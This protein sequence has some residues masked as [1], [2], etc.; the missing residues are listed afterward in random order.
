MKQKNL[1]NMDTK[2]YNVI[3][4]DDEIDSYITA[5]DIKRLLKSKNINIIAT[6]HTSYELRRAIDINYDRVDAVITDANYGDKDINVSDRSLKGLEDVRLCIEKYNERRIIPFY[7]YTGKNE[8]LNDHYQDD[9]LRY[10]DENG[11][12]FTKDET[13]ELFEKIIADVEHINSIEF[14]VRNKY[15]KQLEYAAV[16]EGNDEFLFR[17]LAYEYND[18][19]QNTEDYF[20]SARK[21]VERILVFC[22]NYNVIPTEINTINGC[23][24]FLRGIHH[25]FIPTEE[26]M[27]SALAHSLEFFLNITQD[28]SHGAGDLKLNVDKYVRN[29]KNTNLFRSILYIAM[30]LMEWMVEFVGRHTDKEANKCLYKLNPKYK[31][32]HQGIVYEERE[33]VC[34]DYTII[35]KEGL[36]ICEGDRIGILPGKV[37]IKNNKKIVYSDGFVIIEH[38]KY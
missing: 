22:K 8:Y 19:W 4:A 31:F 5:I 3:W 7:L 1:K 35:P 29:T 33:L 38:S 36:K 16:L 10:F 34:G 12:R 26:I 18:D 9:E 13:K 20:N 23:S 11:R 15:R 37:K 6:A 24:T 30:D 2:F 28:G 27:P 25:L 21:V 14:R 17:A 32:E